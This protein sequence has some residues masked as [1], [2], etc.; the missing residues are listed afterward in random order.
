M[1]Q[2]TPHERVHTLR[3]DKDPTTPI[4]SVHLSFLRMHYVFIVNSMSC[5]DHD[6]DDGAGDPILSTNFFDMGMIWL[7]SSRIFFLPFF[8]LLKPF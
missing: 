1:V 6:D 2:H 8:M 7:Y 5:I 3:K 4:K